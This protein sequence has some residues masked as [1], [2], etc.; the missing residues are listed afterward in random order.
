MDGSL[1]SC[2]LVGREDI[3]FF[4]LGKELFL[5]VYLLSDASPILRAIKLMAFNTFQ[6]DMCKMLTLL[7]YLNNRSRATTI[8]TVLHGLEDL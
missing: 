7:I 1:S 4:A 5:K 2:I 6:A 8:F 3:I